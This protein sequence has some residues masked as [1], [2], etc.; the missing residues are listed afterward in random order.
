MSPARTTASCAATERA[1]G[2]SPRARLL[3]AATPSMASSGSRWRR[4]EAEG[5]GQLLGGWLLFKGRAVDHKCLMTRPFALPAPPP[6]DEMA[7]QQI[8]A[9]RHQGGSAPTLATD[10]RK[11]RRSPLCCRG[12]P[13]APIVRRHV[14]RAVRLGR[15]AHSRTTGTHIRH[16]CAR[17]SAPA[18]EPPD[19]HAR[20]GS[21]VLERATRAAELR[22][23]GD[24]ADRPA[25]RDRAPLRARR[26]RRFHRPAGRRDAPLRGARSGHPR[27]DRGAR[28]APFPGRITDPR[29]ERRRA[30][31]RRHGDRAT[32][33]AGPPRER[34]ASSGRFRRPRRPLPRWPSWPPV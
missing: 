21:H 1:A 23:A 28:P 6:G 10:P 2:D 29:R 22:P 11:P 3:V 30:R 18:G 34:S 8:A 13:L 26:S 31:L 16:G 4:K 15:R 19:P 14:G 32:V 27:S 5:I 7:R 25:H 12:T 33:R 17:R 20:P 9:S 24:P